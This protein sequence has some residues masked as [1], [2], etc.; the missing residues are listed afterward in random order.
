MSASSIS[1][2]SLSYTGSGS[3]VILASAS[4][5]GA[6]PLCSSRNT[7]RPSFKPSHSFFFS[8][9]N[10]IF[11]ST[12][13]LSSPFWV[14][15]SPARP[16]QTGSASIEAS[17][18]AFIP[19]SA[20]IFTLILPSSGMWMEAYLAATN[21]A[22]KS[23]P[24]SV[25]LISVKM[26]TT[27][28]LRDPSRTALSSSS[29]APLLMW[30][31]HWSRLPNI[32]TS[33]LVSAATELSRWRS[34][35]LTA[36]PARPSSSAMRTVLFA[37]SSY[38]SS[39]FPAIL[40]NPPTRESMGVSLTIDE[41]SESIVSTFSLP[42]LLTRSQ[43]RARSRS[44][45]FFAS[46]SVCASCGSRGSAPSSALLIAEMTR[47]CISPA[48]FLVNVSARTSSGL[49]TRARSVK[50]LCMR[51]SVFPDPAGASTMNEREGS[52]ASSRAG[53]STSPSIAIAISLNVIFFSVAVWRPVLGYP[54]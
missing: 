45:A 7:M 15:K 25:A 4:M 42:G 38:S 1:H 28:L 5:K 16:R 35:F 18:S 51:S 50:N 43:P 13:F 14:N 30:R 2:S 41:Q 22:L 46:R 34:A 33:L 32:M 48:A 9:G 49:S 53:A 3:G 26:W 24:S 31:S 10:P 47:L 20:L 39:G 54:A 27:S 21:I 29:S 19:T 36:S 6:S 12:F 17:G 44:S 8:A 11:L 37:A 23:F 52:S 40:S